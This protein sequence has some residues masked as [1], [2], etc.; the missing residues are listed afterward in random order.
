MFAGERSRQDRVEV[1]ERLSPDGILEKS[2]AQQRET[3]ERRLS[4]LF[5]ILTIG[6]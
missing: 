2:A 4:L 1:K 6:S 3:P 5:H